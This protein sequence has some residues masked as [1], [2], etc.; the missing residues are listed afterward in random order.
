MIRNIILLII[1][2]LVAGLLGMG[3]L[4]GLILWMARILFLVFIVLLL[5]SVVT[6]RGPKV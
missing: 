2:A 6:G 3:N 5:L 1:I 4:E